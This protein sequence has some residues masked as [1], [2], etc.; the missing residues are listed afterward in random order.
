MSMAGSYLAESCWSGLEWTLISDTSHCSRTLCNWGEKG[1]GGPCVHR[2]KQPRHVFSITS[3]FGTDADCSTT[4]RCGWLAEVE[5]GWPE[6][7]GGWCR[8]LSRS[9][10]SGWSAK[11]KGTAH[12]MWTLPQKR[13]LWLLKPVLQ[14]LGPINQEIH[15]GNAGV[16]YLWIR[17]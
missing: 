9:P 17:V 4:S 7:V 2:V 16:L 14:L 8:S 5:V 6:R 11:W 3:S 12:C 13:V 10:H 1:W 15:I